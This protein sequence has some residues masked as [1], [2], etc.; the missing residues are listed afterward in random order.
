MS[1]QTAQ[2]CIT[3][4]LPKPL[5]Q[6]WARSSRDMRR[7]SECKLCM[8]ARNTA[9][10]RG[11]PE[12]NNDHSYAMR[13]RDQARAILTGVRHRAKITGVAFSITLDDLGPIPERCPVLGLP[14]ISRMGTGSGGRNDS[15]SIDRIENDKGYVPGN[16][17]W[18]SY[19]ANRIKCNATTEELVKISEFYKCLRP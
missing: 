15:P 18:V 9:W 8:R 10:C 1:A 5:D 3:C 6:F 7:R 17:M 12:H 4:E 13:R 2:I 16:V 11:N 14:L 19:R